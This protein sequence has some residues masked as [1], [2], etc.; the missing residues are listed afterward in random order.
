MTAT[1]LPD[2]FDMDDVNDYLDGDGPAATASSLGGSQG[3]E[4]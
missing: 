3:P 1:I 2:A 4:C